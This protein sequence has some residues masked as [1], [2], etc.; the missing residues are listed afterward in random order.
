VRKKNSKRRQAERLKFEKALLMILVVIL[1]A[2]ILL[3]SD[4][5]EE[6]DAGITGLAVMNEE[7]LQEIGYEH[8]VEV[9]ENVT[10]DVWE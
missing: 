1:A 6:F 4:Q 3:T 9:V 8:E 2:E 10:L 5:F 7:E